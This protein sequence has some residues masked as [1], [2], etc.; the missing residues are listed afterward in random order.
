MKRFKYSLQRVL[1]V[2]E[3]AVSRCEAILAGSERRLRDRQEEERH[4]GAALGVASDELVRAAASKNVRPAHE[5]IAQR[6]WV[7]HLADRS[8]SAAVASQKQS[9]AVDK[10]RSELRKAM[11]DHKVIENLS[12]RERAEWLADVRRTEQKF[13]DEIAAQGIERRRRAARPDAAAAHSGGAP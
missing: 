5:C 9:A 13:M 1:E 3:V 8:R 7:E 11:V 12:H 10:H 2:R 6:A 4:C